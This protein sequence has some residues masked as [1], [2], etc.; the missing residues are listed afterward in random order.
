MRVSGR[1]E[2]AFGVVSVKVTCATLTLPNRQ[3]K[4]PPTRARRRGWSRIGGLRHRV[5]AGAALEQ[6]D[7]E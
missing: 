7:D 3:A 6:L 5:I 2:W 1:D 4:L